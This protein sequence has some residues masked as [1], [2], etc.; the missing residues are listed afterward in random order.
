MRS[1]LIMLCVDESVDSHIIIE[2]IWP[3]IQYDRKMWIFDVIFFLSFFS[4]LSLSFY[5]LF[6]FLEFSEEFIADF[7]LEAFH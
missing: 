3:G 5:F 7:R 6:L 2:P 4:C 1:W